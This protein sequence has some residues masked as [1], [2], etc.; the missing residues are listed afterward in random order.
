MFRNEFETALAAGRRSKENGIEPS[1]P[2]LSHRLRGFLYT[3]IGEQN[4]VY[5]S[6]SG[7]AR[8]LT[9]AVA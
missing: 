2:K 1:A 3:E 5:T 7:I 9:E 4:A 8:Q 6:L